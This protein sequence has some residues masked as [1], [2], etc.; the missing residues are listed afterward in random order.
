MKPIKDCDLE[1]LD[2]LIMCVRAESAKQLEKWGIQDRHIF[3]W[4][5]WTTEEFGEFIKEINEYSY[6]REETPEKVIKEGIQTV[7]LILKMLDGL[8]EQE[9]LQ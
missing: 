4:A 8:L 2:Y 5:M 3:E 6:G 7:T 9:A 1:R